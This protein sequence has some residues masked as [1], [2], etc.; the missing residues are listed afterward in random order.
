ML[1]EVRLEMLRG[2]E[3]RPFQNFERSLFLLKAFRAL[4]MVDIKALLASGPKSLPE[5]LIFIAREQFFG[6]DR[7]SGFGAS[8]RPF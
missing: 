5:R 6:L 2:A 1:S 7:I 3:F 8:R 4:S